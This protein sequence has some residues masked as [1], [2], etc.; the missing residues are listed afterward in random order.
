MAVPIRTTR[1]SQPRRDGRCAADSHEDPKRLPQSGANHAG[2]LARKL[3][4][5]L[6]RPPAAR[7]WWATGRHAADTSGDADM[8][9]WARGAEAAFGLYAPRPLQSVVML[10]LTARHLAGGRVSPG[11]MCAMSA[12]AQAMAAL[13][14]HRQAQRILDDLASLCG[15]ARH[16]GSAPRA[17]IASTRANLP[18]RVTDVIVNPGGSNGQGSASPGRRLGSASAT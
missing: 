13:G 6:T 15:Y 12:E 18:I 5:I 9:V 8:R 17:R 11:L 4:A 1:V 16:Q 14:S 3:H 7:R 2:V 10:A